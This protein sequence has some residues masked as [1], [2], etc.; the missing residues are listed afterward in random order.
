MSDAGSAAATGDTGAAGAAAGAAGTGAAAAPW[1][2]SLKGEADF[3]G[4]LQTRGLDKKTALDAAHDFYKA[5]REAQQMIS[6]VT[7]TPDKERILIRPKDD[8]PEAERT[9]FYERLGR[10][11]KAEEYDFKDVKFPDGT[12]LDTDFSGFLKNAAFKANLS[13]VD[14]QTLARETVAYFQKI[15][16]DESTAKQG[17]IAQALEKLNK[18]WGPNKQAFQFIADQGLAKLAAM[19][20]LTPE[21]TQKALGTIAESVGRF[22]AAQMLLAV[23]KAFGEDKYVA[24]SGNASGIMTREQAA[25]SLKE[26]KMEKGPDSFGAKLMRGDAATKARFEAL[27]AMMVGQEG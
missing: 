18:S 22:E 6:R 14:A 27:T 7:G 19:A 26:L 24:G 3:V 9:A 13:K 23:G 21:Q 5:H 17:E 15:D 4:T 16:A 2:D 20:N 1:F 10:P 25:A 8:A 12:E 11:A